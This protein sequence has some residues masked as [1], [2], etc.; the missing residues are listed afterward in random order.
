MDRG[1]LTGRTAIE[2]AVVHI[3]DVLE[4]PEY[5]SGESIELGRFRTML[6]VPLMREGTCI[7]VIAL[8]RATVRPFAENQ[9]ELVTTF[10][11][12]AVIAIENVRLFDE[13]QART[14]EL[15]EALEYQTATGDVLNVI[16]RSPDKLQPVLDAIVQT[17]ARICKA[18]VADIILAAGDKIEVRATFGELGRPVGEV[19]PL[20]RSTVMGRSIIDRMPVHVADLQDTGHD[21]PRGREFALRFGHRTILAVPLLRDSRALGTILLRRPVIEPFSDKQIALLRTFADQAVIAIENVA[22]VRRGAGADAGARAFGRGAS[23][24]R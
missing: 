7:G 12:Q 24:T 20:D 1:T 2:R 10:A 14:R 23:G 4:D 5:T 16:S 9:I 19:I 3:H 11:D 21:F 15:Q 18:R 22:V 13:V 17:A 8:T 6:G